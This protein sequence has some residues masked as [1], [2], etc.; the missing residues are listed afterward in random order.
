MNNTFYDKCL[1]LLMSLIG[2]T[3][4]N[5]VGMDYRIGYTSFNKKAL[6][7]LLLQGL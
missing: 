4:V 7:I 6:I 3:Y 1:Y 2:Y 5:K